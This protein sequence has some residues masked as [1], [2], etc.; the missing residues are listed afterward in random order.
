LD[1]LEEQRGFA[2]LKM[3]ELLIQGV[4]YGDCDYG[5]GWNSTY[6]YA[7]MNKL[8]AENLWP[9]HFVHTS[10][11]KTVERAE[12]MPDP[13]PSE[14]ST[15]CNMRQFHSVTKYRIGRSYRLE[16][17]NN[18]IELCRECVRAIGRSSKCKE[19]PH[20]SQD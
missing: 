14:R 8:E 18:N 1:L 17:F 9:E 19:P 20:S 4:N 15:P 2:G 16:I 13:M 7:Y 12:V 10:I 6:G 3:S 11:S 5:C